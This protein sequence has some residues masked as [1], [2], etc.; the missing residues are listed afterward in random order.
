MAH[1][2]RPRAYVRE[3]PYGFSAVWGWKTADPS[4]SL[5]WIDPFVMPCYTMVPVG[6]TQLRWVWHAWVPIDDHSHW[7]Y[8]VHYDPEIDPGP[9]ERRNL[10]QTF[11]H[12]LIDPDNDYRSRANS[13][14]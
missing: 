10:E 7:L 12:D 8:Y 3:L 14:N 11:G 1:D 5:F 6:R 13:A 2:K 4:K 9:E